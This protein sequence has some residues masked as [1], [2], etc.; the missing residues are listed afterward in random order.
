M[1]PRGFALPRP[2]STWPDSPR[3]SKSAILIANAPVHGVAGEDVFTDRSVHK[4]FRR[5]HRDL[6]SGHVFLSD[7]AL[8]AGVVI[9]VAVG[10]DH[11]HDWLFA[12]L[13]VI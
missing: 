9:D 8:D 3:G 1:A 4:S 13:L 12:P 10:V 11:R 5:Q 7:D 6:A 2:L